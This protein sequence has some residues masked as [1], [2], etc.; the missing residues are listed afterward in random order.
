MDIIT[1][2]KNL[3]KIQKEKEKLMPLSRSIVQNCAKAIRLAHTYEE[4]ASKTM[5]RKIR[6]DIKR[7]QRAINKQPRLAPILITPEQEWVELEI[8]IA[9]M[10]GH[11]LPEVNSTPQAYLLGLMDG[12]GECKRV[13]LDM[14]SEGMTEDADEALDWLEDTYHEVHA[15][16]FPNSIVPGLKH[17]QDAMKRVLDSLHASIREAETREHF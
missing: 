6:K 14:L 13:V 2:R 8:L 7:L 12:I 9:F 16:A 17:K 5:L 10:D 3:T 4:K 11:D 1:A 15:M